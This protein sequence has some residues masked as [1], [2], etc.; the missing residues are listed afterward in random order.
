MM[1]ATFFSWTHQI[2]KHSF[3]DIISKQVEL[4]LLLKYKI[5]FISVKW[6]RLLKI[7]NVVMSYVSQVYSGRHIFDC[8]APQDILMARFF[9][10]G[11]IFLV[12][13]SKDIY[14]LPLYLTLCM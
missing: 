2:N 1:S 5:I 10:D 11:N 7:L 12:N 8:V 9:F 3:S 14:H 4:S 6:P 13:V